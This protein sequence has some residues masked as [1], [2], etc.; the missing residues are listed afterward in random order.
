MKKKV[1]IF[2]PSFEKG[3]IEQNLK[4]IINNL[5]N[6]KEIHLISSINR[7]EFKKIFNRKVFLHPTTQKKYF[8]FLPARF[9]SAFNGMLTLKRIIVK[10]G[11]NLI[12]HSMQSNIAAF[13][14]CFIYKKKI[15][16]RNS[17][18]PIYSTIYSENKFLSSIVF[19][20]KILTYNFVSGIITNSEG[21]RNSLSKFIFNK[22]KI[23]TIYN[24]YLQKKNKKKFKKEKIIL[25]IG[26]LRKQKDHI[27]LIKAFN[28]FSRVNK[29]YKLVILGHGDQEHKIN[30]EIKKLKLERKVF[31]KGWVNNTYSYLKKSKLFVLSSIYEGLGNVLIDAINYNVPCISTNCKSGPNEILLNGKGGFLGEPKNH[32]E[33]ARLMNYA[34]D[35]YSFSIRKNEYAKKHL[36]RFDTKK[37]VRKYEIFLNK[38]INK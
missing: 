3:G 1:I 23:K 6:D 2:Y 33:L 22:H 13:F 32:Y 7:N 26:R 25:N 31:V 38:F 37:Q 29:N 28:I 21:S 11:S 30:K 17:E 15:V 9:G 14:I 35:N 16:I 34:I 19:I 4:N 8:S 5:S 20:F 10:L 18:D 24:P 36:N 12:I 27:T